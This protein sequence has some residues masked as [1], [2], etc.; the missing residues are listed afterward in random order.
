MDNPKKNREGYNDP[1]AY[2][3][4]KAVVREDASTEERLNRLVKTLKYI[5]GVAGFELINRIELRDT[6]TGRTYR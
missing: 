4:M 1:T 5:I 2:L 6:K 3:G